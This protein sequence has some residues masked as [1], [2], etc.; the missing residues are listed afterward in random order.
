MR[1]TPVEAYAE[2]WWA[3]REDAYGPASEL[4]PRGAKVR[5]YAAM[6]AAASPGASM[7]VGCTSAASA[8]QVYVAAAAHQ[9]GVPGIVYLPARAQ[10]TAATEYAVALGAEVH[11]VKPGWPSYVR[12]CARKHA[13]SLPAAVAWNSRLALQDTAEQAQNIPAACQ[14][15]VIPTGSGLT[16]AGVLVGLARAGRSHLPVLAVCVSSL[17]TETRILALAAR[18]LPLLYREPALAL[19]R[20]PGRYDAWTP[21]WLPNGAPLDPFY[22]ARAL[23]YVQP[24]DCFWCTGI[25]PLAAMP[26]ACQELYRLKIS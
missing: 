16:A 19:V 12:A 10:P 26:E 24:G 9:A 21:G 6:V 5:Q 22:A 1:L 13:Q 3:K 25:R 2:G 15:V 11:A 8:M 4:Y 17:A 14:R 18:F 7:V 23:P 20:A